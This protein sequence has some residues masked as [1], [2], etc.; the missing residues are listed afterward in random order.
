M[1]LGIFDSGL[2]GALIARAIHCLCPDIDKVYLGD[3]ANLPY[4][5]RS[6]DVIY[7]ASEACIDALFK[8]DCQLIIVACN[9]ASAKALRRLQQDYL[10]K[11]YP[12]RRILGVV[13]PT[14]EHAIENR[15]TKLGVIGT[16]YT[17]NSHIFAHELHKIK[18]DL[19]IVEHATPLLVPL[20]EHGGEA[21]I[22]MILK[23]YLGFTHDACMDALLLGC[24]HYIHL[25][26][27]IREHYPFSVISQDEI[28]PDKLVQYLER[29]PEIETKL[30]RNRK[31]SF[32]LTD[33]TDGYASNIRRLF[34]D[35]VD[36]QLFSDIHDS[37]V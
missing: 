10:P 18:P 35:T 6:E 22:D 13:V 24:T 37:P 8:M 21:Y 32:Y 27:H 23:D 31:C 4:G 3:T 28:I 12:D 25:K 2:G 20:L 19:G 17:I 34:S 26:D 29:H 9:T 11:H 1:K 15:Y 30:T 7:Q 5:G 36:I 33:Y 16:E 14:I